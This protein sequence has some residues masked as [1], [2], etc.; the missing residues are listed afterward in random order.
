VAVADNVGRRFHRECHFGDVDRDE[1]R[2]RAAEAALE[3][4]KNV[5]AAG[6]DDSRPQTE[7]HA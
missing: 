7:Q 3:L 1:G 6:A 4:L 5:F 2:D